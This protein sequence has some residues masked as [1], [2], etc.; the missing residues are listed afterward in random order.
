MNGA[1]ALVRTMVNAGVD[2]SFTNP[3]TSEMHFVAALDRVE[4]MRCV[5]CLFEGGATGAADGYAR[6]ADKPAATLLHLGP[7]LA[8]G[9]ANIHNARR[10]GTPMLNIVGEHTSFH[11][12][13]DAPLT[14]DIEALARPLSHFVR[15]GSHATTIAQDGA[16]AIVAAREYPGKI[17]TLI[18]P[19]DTAWGGSNGPVKTPK[20]R[21]R[22]KIDDD[23]IHES[24]E[25]LRGGPALLLIGDVGLRAGA[26]ENAS[27]IAQKLNC[28][29]MAPMSNKRVERG[30]G[31]VA[32]DRVPY[33]VDIAVERLKDYR[34]I[35]LVGA[36]PPVAFFGY[37]NKPSALTHPDADF[38][39][40][41][42]TGDDLADALERLCDHVGAGAEKPVLNAH[43]E[44]TLPSG[45]AL[46]PD[47]IGPIL[48]QLLPE[49]A[50]VCDESVS[51]GRNFFSSTHSAPPHDWLS[52]TGGAIGCGIPLATGAAV[53]APGRKIVNL[54]ADG[55]AM[56]TLQALWTQARE[57]LNI[58]TLIWAN[59]A[60]AI[61]RGE[62]MNVG[63]ENPGRK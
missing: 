42:E 50:V 21:P 61:L 38:F 39:T 54:Q 43:M 46:T 51:T 17:A 26:L 37:P 5:L 20:Q 16:D 23:A 13:F 35:V 11:K 25:F 12:R 58:L 29:I 62:L 6:M 22:K 34:R 60:Y 14:S 52:I 7:G 56:Y 15:T 3:G 2:V 28:A 47:V 41:A 63:A 31:R 32:I 33:P 57:N 45:G 55:S 48:G 49:G 10:A 44:K 24:A 4:G 30:A 1:E 59:H 27:R 36:K 40:L 18:L 8:N 9:L 19:A 53:G